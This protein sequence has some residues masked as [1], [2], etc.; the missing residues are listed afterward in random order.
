MKKI[1]LLLASA[2]VGLTANAALSETDFANNNYIN[3]WGRLK[4]VGNQL[5]SESGQPVQLKGWSTF[6]W[7]WGDCV[8][9]QGENAFT[10]M[11]AYGANVL[12]GAMYVAEGGAYNSDPSTNLQHT[13]NLIDW[14]EKNGMY[15]LCDWHVLS[16]GDPTDGTYNKATQYFTDVTNY[17][18]EKGYKHVLYE[19][20]NE[21][22]SGSGSDVDGV[23]RKIKQY[24]NTVLPIIQQNDPGAIVVVGTPEW[25]Q[26]PQKAAQDPITGYDNLNLMYAFHFYSCSHSGFFSNLDQACASVPVFISEWGIADFSGGEG[27]RDVAQYC[28][29][30]AKKLINQYANGYNQGGQKLSWCCWSTGNK[31]EQASAFEG[32]CS[33]FQLS[34][35]GKE[36]VELMGGN[37]EYVAPKTAC[38]GGCQAVPGIVDL[39]KYD[40]DPES[41]GPETEGG[42]TVRGT[43]EGVTYSEQNS[44]DD[45]KN[46][47]SLCNG[48]YK[49]GGADYEFRI[50]ECV[51]VS[52]CYGMTGA[53]GWHNLAYME[54]G[55]W[56]LITLDVE[57]PG[58]YTIEG[59]C[60]TETV[61]MFGITSQTYFCNLLYDLNT[62]EQLPGCGLS[63]EVE[64]A[65]NWQF[66]GWQ[67][68]TVG[69]N[70]VTG[71]SMTSANACVLFKEAG[72]H[73]IKFSIQAPDETKENK[74]ETLGSLGPIKFELA[75][76]YTGPGYDEGTKVESVASASGVELFPNP[77]NDVISA[78][79]EASKIEVVSLTGAVIASANGNSVN[80]ASLATGSYIA[81]IYTANGVVVK[82]FV[83]K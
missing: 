50:D 19:I 75:E 5:S 55:E 49:W 74:I 61:V 22:N 52:G 36:V 33:N 28:I 12:R 66:W 31:N 45:E 13:K 6:G 43:S 81:K 46:D 79:V 1:L 3:E 16:P 18:K 65:N 77:A 11:K 2:F 27:T 30:D 57:E 76:P 4:L 24:A 53:E 56:L 37:S 25:D 9:D 70:D 78:N 15:Y 40:Q 8:I 72:K 68:P 64:G 35:T 42:L 54:P 39:G 71:S 34:K 63:T 62:K 10:V 60:N 51:D 80:I 69:V 20:C 23:W 7:M 67:A 47:R 44:T 32:G 17:V 41:E 59:L 38:Y 73:T 58:Y 29:D 26:H 14:A 83:K 48:A 82:N 21:P